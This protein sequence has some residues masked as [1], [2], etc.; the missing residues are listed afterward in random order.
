[1]LASAD[2][3][4]TL[5]RRL[6]EENRALSEQ[7]L[8]R[9]RE[10]L[11][12]AEFEIFPTAELLDHIPA[13]LAAIATDLEESEGGQISSSIVTAK[14]RELGELRYNQDASVHQ[15]L[16]E[17]EHL[18][19]VLNE[20]I[21]KEI[22]ELG[23]VRA[24]DVLELVEQINYAIRTLM[25]TTIDTFTEKFAK[26]I[27]EQH[28]RL[29]SFNQMVSHELRNPMHS[30]RLVAELLGN[31]GGKAEVYPTVDSLLKDGVDRIDDILSNLERMSRTEPLQ[32]RS[33]TLQQVCLNEA[34]GDVLRELEELIDDQRIDVRIQ[35]ELPTVVIDLANFSIVASN[36]LSN[37]VKYSDPGEHERWIEITRLDNSSDDRITICFR[38]NGLGIAADALP[39]VF[40]RNYRGD[41]VGEATGH[42]LGLYVVR[43]CIDSMGGSIHVRSEQGEGTS[44]FVTV[45]IIPEDETS[46]PASGDVDVDGV[47]PGLEE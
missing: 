45:P 3:R 13:L 39:H 24:T 18:A 41:N 37:A 19:E 1:M 15:L 28:R 35:K 5:A 21:L 26:T 11:P 36:L 16:R 17:W 30:L 43:R 25:R 8:D 6:K 40:E 20:F 42:G 46:R 9:L 12:V 10:L 2:L 14:A 44:V 38:D 29:E 31:D 33:P 47:A 23:D 34:L 7:W 27:E 22:E 4:V 32:A